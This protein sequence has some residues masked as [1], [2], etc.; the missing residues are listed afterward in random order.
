MLAAEASAGPGAT[1]FSFR[2]KLIN[3]NFSINQRVYVSGAATTGANQYTLDRWRVV[4]SGQNLA[5]SAS[6]NGNSVTAPASGIEQVIEGANIEGGIYTLSWIGAG[7]A[8]VNGSAVTNGG[9]TA[10]LTAGANVTV[11]F[12][13]AV[14]KV[15]LEIG[16]I[17]T[18]FEHRPVGSEMQLCQRYYNADVFPEARIGR[19]SVVGR[20]SKAWAD[21]PVTMR[22]IPTLQVT[23][24]GGVGTQT[25]SA[26]DRCIVVSAGVSVGDVAAL[27]AYTATAE[28]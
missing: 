8:T 10:S 13:G 12:V 2:N 28:L 26:S 15:Q 6:G 17:D 16:S 11:K 27:A 21:F 3:G 9:Q 5:F 24:T 19:D 1:P 18:P 25:A 23:T 7:T 20:V 14:S 22:A 4:T